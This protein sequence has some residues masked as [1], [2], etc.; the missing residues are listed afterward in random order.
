MN[1]MSVQ[2]EILEVNKIILNDSVYKLS[3]CI[4]NIFFVGRLRI[5]S[6]SANYLDRAMLKK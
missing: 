4:D 3:E 1:V 6:D 5:T 2:L